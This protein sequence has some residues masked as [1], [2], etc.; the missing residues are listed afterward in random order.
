MEQVSN[1]QL[2]QGRELGKQDAQP[3][4]S[5]EDLHVSFHT[6]AGEV[7]AVRGATYS[8]EHGGSL[9]VVGESGCGKTVTV[10]TVMGLTPIPPGEIKGGKIIFNGQDLLQMSERE[11]QSIRGKDIGMIFQDPMT[12]L[13]PT[14]TVGR[15]IAETVERHHKVSRNEAMERAVEMLSLVEIPNPQVRARQYP[16]Q[17]SG[18][19][20]QRAMIAMALAC[21][22]LLLIADE[23]TTSLDV[24]IQSQI[25]DLLQNLQERLG[26]TIVLISHNLG[27]VARLAKSI[28]VMYAGKVVESGP[29][30]EIFYNAAH[31]YTQALLK[32]VPRLDQEIRGEL[33]TIPGTPPDLFKPP[34]GCAFAPRCKYAMKICVNCD[35]EPIKVG[36]NHYVSCWLHHEASPNNPLKNQAENGGRT[37]D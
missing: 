8:V 25:L 4:L 20:R 10:Q 31:P 17:F 15:Q 21:E 18:G 12:G 6:Y 16:H 7:H 26:M 22:P 35:A 11:K 29:A 1:N 9:A 3:L 32:S 13:N 2:N 37:S 28:V 19:M 24:T 14:M 34:A 27:V 23:P 36:D 30:S 33:A 5:I